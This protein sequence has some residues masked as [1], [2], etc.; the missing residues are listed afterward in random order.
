MENIEKTLFDISEAV[1]AFDKEKTAKL[2]RVL[3]EKEVEPKKIIR[4]GLIIG[5]DY[6]IGKF[7]TL[8]DLKVHL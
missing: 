4:D 2:V 5:I 8:V 7:K 1:K 6:V 3:V